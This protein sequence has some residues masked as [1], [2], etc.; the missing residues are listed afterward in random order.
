MAFALGDIIIDR[1]QY[2]YAEDFSGTPLYTLTQL[3]DATINI[4]AESTDAVDN[5]GAIVKRFW[6]AKTGEFTANNAMINLN[7]IAAGAG[8]G[9]ATLAE[10]KKVMMDHFIQ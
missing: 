1:V 6:K 10:T 5:T 8:E 4:S 2:G 7:I 9:S 3:Q